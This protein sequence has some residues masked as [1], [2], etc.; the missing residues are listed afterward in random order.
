VY[1]FRPGLMLPMPGQKNLK[2]AY[3]VALVA[4]P[5]MKLFFPALTL[6]TVADAMINA[7][8]KGAPKHVLEVADIAALGAN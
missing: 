2:T 1:N 5:I 6:R 7:T 8:L 3:R 4:A